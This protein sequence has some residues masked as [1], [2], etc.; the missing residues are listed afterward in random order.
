MSKFIG[1]K[2]IKEVRELEDKTPSGF[3]IKEVTF[4]DESV[5]WFSSVMFEHVQSDNRCDDTELRDKRIQPMV[6]V[7]LAILRDW[8]VKVGELPYLSVLLTQ[9]L[10][11]NTSEAVKEMWSK[12]MPKPADLDEVNLIAVDRVLKTIQTDKSAK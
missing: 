1:K 9:S 12:F 2:K 6:Q 5:E 7:I 10:D 4:D 8:G 11:N 3:P